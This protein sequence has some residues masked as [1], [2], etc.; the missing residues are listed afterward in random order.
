MGAVG[1]VA[2]LDLLASAGSSSAWSSASL[3]IFWISASLRPV[4][5]WMTIFCSLPVA[6]SL[7]ETFRMPLASMS[8]VTSTCGTPRGAGRMPSRMKRPSDLFSV[9]IGRSPCSTCTSTLVWPSA[10][11]V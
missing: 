6:L 7:A 2:R 9:A 11:V 1:V 3:T 8:K 5:D 4:D 10:A